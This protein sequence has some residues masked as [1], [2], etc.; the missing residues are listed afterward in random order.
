MQWKLYILVQVVIN[1]V[2]AVNSNTITN[3]LGN[4]PS[5]VE[6]F[7]PTSGAVS[8]QACLKTPLPA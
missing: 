5:W 7:N 3:G 6:L 8:L 1:E 4:T 2:Q